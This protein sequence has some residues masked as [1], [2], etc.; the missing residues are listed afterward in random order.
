MEV[1]NGTHTLEF[2]FPENPEYNYSMSYVVTDG[3]LPVTFPPARYEASVN[4]DKDIKIT[5]EEYFE[6][7][8]QTVGTDSFRSEKGGSFG[9]WII[10]ILVVGVGVVVV[11]KRK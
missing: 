1:E 9:Y 3:R 2:T 8:A 10:L 5:S 7:I 11:K 4:I 6:A